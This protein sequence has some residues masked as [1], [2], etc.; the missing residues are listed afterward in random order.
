MKYVI[1][2]FSNYGIRENNNKR[3]PKHGQIRDGDFRIHS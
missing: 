2:I 1:Y 3:M